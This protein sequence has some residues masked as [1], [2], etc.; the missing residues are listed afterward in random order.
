MKQIELTNWEAAIIEKAAAPGLGQADQRDRPRGARFGGDQLREILEA[1][2]CR[3]QHLGEALGRGPARAPLAGDALRFVERGGIESGTF[4]EPGR[5][6]AIAPR[7]RVDGVPYPGVGEPVQGKRP[8]CLRSNR[9][10][11]LW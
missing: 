9:N 10:L 5:R 7:Q 4:G 11:C 2:A 6:K 3:L 8:R 1:G